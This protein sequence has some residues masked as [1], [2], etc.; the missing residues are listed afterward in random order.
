MI[1]TK[2]DYGSSS[3]FSNSNLDEALSH[4]AALSQELCFVRDQVACI[5]ASFEHRVSKKVDSWSVLI[6]AIEKIEASQ[7]SVF[8]DP[9]L[10]RLFCDMRV[11][12]SSSSP[13]PWLSQL[14]KFRNNWFHR[15]PIRGS[16]ANSPLFAIISFDYQSHDMMAIEL[17]IVCEVTSRSYDALNFFYH[18]WVRLSAIARRLVYALNVPLTPV[19]LTMNDIL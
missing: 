6:K 7:P 3:Q 1:L 8:N 10:Y 18:C 17:K 2:Q 11:A 13:D 9:T 15:A 12:A 16:P 4:L 14:T 5:L 19:V